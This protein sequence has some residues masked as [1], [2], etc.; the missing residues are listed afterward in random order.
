MPDSFMVHSSAFISLIRTAN[1]NIYFAG[2][3]PSQ[4]ERVKPSLDPE[5]SKTLGLNMEG[6]SHFSEGFGGEKWQDC[7][8]QMKDLGL[9]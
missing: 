7:S 8:D 6:L 2:I 5:Q 9:I 3:G 4:H 1:P